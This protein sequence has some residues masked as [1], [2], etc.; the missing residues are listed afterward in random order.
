MR[1]V[2]IAD[3]QP[4]L[5]LL[6]RTT[7]AS[8]DY[9]VV[10]AAD[11]DAAWELIRRHRPALAL[12]D[13]QMPGRTGLEL[14]RAIKADPELAGTRVVLLTSKAQAGDV[15]AGLEAGADRYLTKPFS[16]LELLTLVERTL[17]AG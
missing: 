2:V 4:S 9:A 17:A 5:R 13:V 1:T 10:E 14:A 8:N 12:L 15:Q 3:D 6:V 7:I 16:P 11:G